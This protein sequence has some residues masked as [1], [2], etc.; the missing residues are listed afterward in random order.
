VTTLEV[1]RYDEE[2]LA[3]SAAWLRDDETA[4][5][6]RTPPFSDEGQRQWFDGLAA[7]R[8]YAVWGVRLAGEPVGAFGLKHITDDSA[9]YWGYLGVKGLW[10][11]GHGSALVEAGVD[12]AV[13]RGLRRLYLHVGEDNP[14]ATRLYARHGFVEQSRADDLVLMSRDLSSPRS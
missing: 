13:A 3:C 9:E 10:G 6:T 12:A 4:R 14:R 1:V 5:L 2:F 11:E 8:D 7:R